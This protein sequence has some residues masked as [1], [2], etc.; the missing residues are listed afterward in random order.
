MR[1]ILLFAVVV[2]LS[3]PVSAASAAAPSKSV[4]T[5]LTADVTRI[6]DANSCC[7]I[8]RDLEG[9]ARFSPFGRLRFAGEYDLVSHYFPIYGA[10]TA[11][12]LTFVAR[13]GDSFTI[14][15]LSDFFNFGESPPAGTWSI[16]AATGR[17]SDY[18]GSGTYAITG[19][20]PGNGFDTTTPLTISLVGTVTK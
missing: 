19:L 8:A 5:T 3:V 11:L 12:G 4:E 10:T 2:A 6:W 1:W 20:D 13:N 18:T 9:T 16:V 17:F 7:A 14:G 15:G